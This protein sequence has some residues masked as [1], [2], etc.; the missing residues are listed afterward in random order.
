MPSGKG[1]DHG[2]LYA[3]VDVALPKTL[4]PEQKTHFEALK[5][6]DASS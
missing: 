3:R 1:S 6:L 4:T 5:K 2:D